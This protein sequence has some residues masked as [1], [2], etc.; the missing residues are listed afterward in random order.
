MENSDV[1]SANNLT[2]DMISIDRSLILIGKKRG[3]KIDLCRTPD[4]TGNH[5]DV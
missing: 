4:L 3:P 1:S 2:V 5:S